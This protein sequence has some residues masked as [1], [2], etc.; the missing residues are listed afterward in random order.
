M[1]ITTTASGFGNPLLDGT[2]SSGSLTSP[3]SSPT[4]TYDGNSNTSGNV[5][6]KSMSTGGV[7]AIVVGALVAVGAILVFSCWVVSRRLSH[8]LQGEDP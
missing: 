8:R 1:S 4:Q 7:I 5:S 3:A 2:T 6:T